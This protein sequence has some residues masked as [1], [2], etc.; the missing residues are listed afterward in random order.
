MALAKAQM[1]KIV[2]SF[3]GANT[4]TGGE[5]FATPPLHTEIA[6]CNPMMKVLLSRARFTPFTEAGLFPVERRS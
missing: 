3:P 4:L 1:R 6:R 2:L 5:P